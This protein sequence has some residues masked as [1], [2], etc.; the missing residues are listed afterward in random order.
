MDGR[1]EIAKVNPINDEGFFLGW[2]ENLR[3]F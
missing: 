3:A 1:Q 2:Y